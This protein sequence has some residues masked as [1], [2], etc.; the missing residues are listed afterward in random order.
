MNRVYRVLLVLMLTL[1]G[2]K[3]NAQQVL[4][5]QGWGGETMN[6]VSYDGTNSKASSS[7]IGLIIGKNGYLDFKPGW[8]LTVRAESVD[9]GNGKRFPVDKIYLQP[10]NIEAPSNVTFTDLGVKPRTQIM[11]A[12]MASKVIEYSNY[13]MKAEH[14]FQLKFY[15]EPGILGGEYLGELS[16]VNQTEY[17]II[18]HFSLYDHNDILVSNISFA[19]KIQVASDLSGTPPVENNFSISVSNTANNATL[20]LSTK[21]HYEEGA[22]VIYNNGL[23]VSSNT[24]YQITVKSQ[25]EVF[26]STETKDTLPSKYVNVQL[27]DGK[28][29]ELSTQAKVLYSDKSTDSKPRNYDIIYS[30]NKPAYLNELFEVDKAKYTTNLIYE[31]TVQ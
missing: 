9:A 8:W 30:I 7:N 15:L 1:V 31:I 17:P 6:I 19:Y 21:T 26:Y 20:D 24:K 3:A 22:S 11:N 23:T 16:N 5:F 4:D 12:N 18:F 25:S 14:Y 2:F 13:N 27:S 10:K 28:M 29:V